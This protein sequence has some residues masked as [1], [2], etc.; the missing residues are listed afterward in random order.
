MLALVLLV[1]CAP[2]DRHDFSPQHPPTS[3]LADT[4]DVDPAARERIIETIGRDADEG[5]LRD[6]LKERP[7]NIDAAIA[8]ARSM[9]KRKCPDEALEVLDSALLVAP[10]NLRAL[11]AKAVVLDYKGRHRDAQELYNQA[12]ATAPS[13]SMLRNNLRF[14]HVLEGEPQAETADP[15]QAAGGRNTL[16]RSR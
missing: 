7:G 11:N 10:G 15:A 16:A 5:A 14:S 13:N 1:G 4:R 8:L 12:L 9:L 2:P 3:E 6:A